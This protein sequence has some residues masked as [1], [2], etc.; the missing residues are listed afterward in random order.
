[1][2]HRVRP[3]RETVEEGRRH[4]MR[5][6]LLV[7]ALANALGLVIGLLLVLTWVE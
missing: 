6:I 1:M 2:A 5:Q 7:L 3:Y 4:A